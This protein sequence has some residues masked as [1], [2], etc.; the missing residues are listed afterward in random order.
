MLTL[1]RV[2]QYDAFLANPAP[3]GSVEAVYRYETTDAPRAAAATEETDEGGII[4]P[5][6]L[7]TALVAG[8][9]GLLVLWA[10]L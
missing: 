6:L 4:L 8:A 10:H 9:G 7:V 5:V 3:G 1:A 2:R